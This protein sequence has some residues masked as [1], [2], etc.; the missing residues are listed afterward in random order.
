MRSP[1]GHRDSASTGT[2]SGPHWPYPPPLDSF[3]Y[4]Y[5]KYQE[6]PGKSTE[7]FS[8][9]E[10]EPAGS[11]HSPLPSIR[12]ELPVTD[13]IC[14]WLSEHRISVSAGAVRPR[15]KGR[16]PEVL[17]GGWQTA[18]SKDSASNGVPAVSPCRKSTLTAAGAATAACRPYPDDRR[19]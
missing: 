2:G 14:A 19:S 8:R 7:A 3:V 17:K 18:R 15:C 1:S 6:S 12:Q 16:V 10:S 11:V 13:L 5:T 4:A 9:Q